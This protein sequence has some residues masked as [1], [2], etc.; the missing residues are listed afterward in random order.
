M[1]I[2]A[3]AIDVRTHHVSADD[4][5]DA[6]WPHVCEDTRSGCRREVRVS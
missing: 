3:H 1:C 4:A 6:H 2:V 5:V